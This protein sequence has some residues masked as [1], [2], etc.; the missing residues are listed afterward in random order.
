MSCLTKIQASWVKLKQ[1]GIGEPDMENGIWLNPN[2]YSI[3]TPWKDD[4]DIVKIVKGILG[5][6]NLVL[7]NTPKTGQINVEKT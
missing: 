4:R 2:M 1:A 7:E 3:L 6:M 5:R